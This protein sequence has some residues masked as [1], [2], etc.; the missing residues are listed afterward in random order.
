MS[1]AKF[2]KSNT[3]VI[4]MRSLFI[5]KKILNFIIPKRLSRI[6]VQIVGNT[7]DFWKMSS[8]FSCMF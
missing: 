3:E 1:T 4:L 8:H 2:F 5:K 7:K 6:F